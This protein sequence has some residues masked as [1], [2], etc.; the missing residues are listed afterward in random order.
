MNVSIQCINESYELTCNRFNLPF[1]LKS[2]FF[3]WDNIML[4][5]MC[6]K[7]WMVNNEQTNKHTHKNTFQKNYSYNCLNTHSWQFHEIITHSYTTEI[8]IYIF[9]LLASPFHVT[10]NWNWRGNCA[11]FTHMERNFYTHNHNQSILL[12]RATYKAQPNPTTKRKK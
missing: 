11:Q 5:L 1:N 7:L 6:V 3:T 12:N 10:I 2:V 8:S 4:K 9:K